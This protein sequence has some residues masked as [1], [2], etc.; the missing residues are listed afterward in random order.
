MEPPSLS[1]LLCD[2]KK[3]TSYVEAPFVRSAKSLG[4]LRCI[5]WPQIL[6]REKQFAP[7]CSGATTFMN[8]RVNEWGF[9][10]FLL[11]MQLPALYFQKVN[12]EGAQFM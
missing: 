2:H 6:R 10:F 8:E 4:I 12:L 5:I 7:L 3:R 1:L 11:V 9:L